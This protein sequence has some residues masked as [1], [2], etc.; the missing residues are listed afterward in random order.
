VFNH[1]DE[2]KCETESIPLAGMVSNL[3]A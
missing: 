1:L 2:K 3:L